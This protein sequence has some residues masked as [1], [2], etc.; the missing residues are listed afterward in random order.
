MSAIASKTSKATKTAKT[1]EPT[2]M[3][4]R[5]MLSA[6]ISDLAVDPKNVRQ[7]GPGNVADLKASIAS[8][9]LLSP[10]TVRLDGKKVL[11][12]AGQRRLKALQELV[13][14][15]V[16]PAGSTVS[17]IE[18]NERDATA[19]SLAENIMRQD[20][21]PADRFTAYQSLI[22]EGRSLQDIASQFGASIDAVRRSLK[23]ANVHPKIVQAL[24]E[25]EIAY[26]AVIAYALSDDH[27]RQYAFYQD[28]PKARAGII[29][30]AMSE[31]H[32]PFTDKRLVLVGDAYIE[33]G[34]GVLEDLFSQ[35]QTNRYA[36]DT[37]LVD[38]LVE[39]AMQAARKDVEGEGWASVII[40]QD[41]N[42]LHQRF[43]ARI[44]PKP[45]E[46]DANQ[47]AELKTVDSQ[48]NDLY[49]IDGDENPD[50]QGQI[51]LLEARYAE[52]THRQFDQDAK[53]AAHALVLLGHNGSII[54]E[55]GLLTSAKST[56]AQSADKPVISA[57]L[58]ADLSA[59]RATALASHL[60]D[61]ETTSLALLANG[62]ITSL[63]KHRHDGLTHISVQTHSY[64][65]PQE[66]I[67]DTLID[68]IA[69]QL[70]DDRPTLEW[71]IDQPM[72]KLTALLASLA[73]LA[74][75]PD[76]AY[77]NDDRK[78]ADTIATHTKFDPIKSLSLT[79]TGTSG[80]LS[81]SNLEAIA[82]EQLTAEGLTAIRA[83]KKKSEAA[84]AFDKA[85]EGKWLPSPL[86]A[87]HDKGE[88]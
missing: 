5:S 30:R 63:L 57:S 62:L 25:D 68:E 21:N 46:L 74:F 39:Q 41:Y 45:I 79:E 73:R 52:L 3:T 36:M 16:L 69:S 83:A 42:D 7:K 20:M 50:H 23:L 15:G 77:G 38:A 34:G 87:F 61:H 81:R 70:P 28:Q 58:H 37:D 18:I 24:R 66:T 71:L 29:K 1:T 43:P 80:R 44:Y 4:E 76:R 12:S 56:K 64:N 84:A 22:E 75:Q 55:R 11:V 72:E 67:R 2:I 60:V 33:A 48:L 26:D 35:D 6:Q 8:Y 82:K 47:D 59:M 17:V 40:A 27:E 19:I 88:S 78:L 49:Q 86:M 54:V 53:S 85:L 10:L 9:G 31:G 65:E 14:D 51:D 32:I 13:K